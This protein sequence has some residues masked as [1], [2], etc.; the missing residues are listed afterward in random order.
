[1]F[2]ASSFAT[3]V[4]CNK[5]RVKTRL[6]LELTTLVV[7]GLDDKNPHLEL[8]ARQWRKL[9]ELAGW[10]S[11][12]GLTWH[13]AKLCPSLPDDLRIIWEE[14]A[15]ATE[16]RSVVYSAEREVIIDAL[17]DSGI[18]VVPLK[19]AVM[20][21][22]Y[23]AADMRSMADN[24]LL[25]GYVEKE[26]DGTWKVAGETE[27]NRRKTLLRAREEAIRIMRSLGYEPD[28]HES[29]DPSEFQDVGLNKPPILRFEMHHMLV[30]NPEFDSGLFSN[31]WAFVTSASS[32]PHS[33][34]FPLSLTPEA[35]YLYFIVHAYKHS[36]TGYI[37]IRFLADEI[38]YLSTP[39]DSIN[40]NTVRMKLETS[41]LDNFEAWLKALALKVK[42]R[43]RLTARDLHDLTQM[44]SGGTY[45][46]E[47]D[48]LTNQLKRNRSIGTWPRVSYIAKA[49]SPDSPQRTPTLRTL[50]ENKLSRPLFPVI[51]CLWFVG[52][53]FREPSV[54]LPKLRAFVMR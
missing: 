6:A 32:D 21:A 29:L 50:A 9:F 45:G 8:P 15:R 18:S 7:C 17:L 43:E 10:N 46:S 13:A 37:G 28:G 42:R 41:G 34:G 20:A 25:Y 16:L 52:R 31:P 4:G 35:E 2:L 49:L 24:D 47:S 51:K 54:M 23:P 30:D 27:M 14:S 11:V 1:M 5:L 39:K 22:R 3:S 36:K 38:V 48:C 19:G 44:A 26:K 40:W 12:T 33:A 53:T